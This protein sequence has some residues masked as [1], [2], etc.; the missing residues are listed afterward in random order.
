MLHVNI[1][2][3]V[4]DSLPA[5][6][7]DDAQLDSNGVLGALE[8]DS[9]SPLARGGFTLLLAVHPARA[10]I[11]S[12]LVRRLGVVCD[13]Q[14]RVPL[15]KFAFALAS[16]V[17]AIVLGVLSLSFFRLNYFQVFYYA[18]YTFIGARS[19]CLRVSRSRQWAFA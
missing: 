1:T 9:V 4:C 14:Y 16:G 7:A 19:R 10:G 3:C 15:P 12:D 2:F 5:G 13:V 18:H 8:F 6:G 17:S 11:L